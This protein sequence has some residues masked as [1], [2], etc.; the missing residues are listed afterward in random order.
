[1]TRING[2]ATKTIFTPN[3]TDDI[4]QC[5]FHSKICAK[6]LCISFTSSA[7]DK[8]MHM[9]DTFQ[10][11]NSDESM[12]DDGPNIIK[13]VFDCINPSLYVGVANLKLQMINLKF[14]EFEGE[15]F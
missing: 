9:K 6:I 7:E 5:R 12:V 10:Y 2:H 11:Q 13:M 14:S 8:L 1:M 3:L 4:N 15:I